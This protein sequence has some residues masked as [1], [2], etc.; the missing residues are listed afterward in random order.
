MNFEHPLR[1]T[2]VDSSASWNG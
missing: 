1:P 2:L